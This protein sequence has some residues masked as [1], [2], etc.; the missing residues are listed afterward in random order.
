M[1]H[2]NIPLKLKIPWGGMR[3]TPKTFSVQEAYP[4]L[5][6]PTVSWRNSYKNKF[7]CSSQ[8]VS[9]CVGEIHWVLGKYIGSLIVRFSYLAGYKSRLRFRKSF[10]LQFG[11]FTRIFIFSNAFESCAVLVK[12]MAKT[13]RSWQNVWTCATE[14]CPF[15]SVSW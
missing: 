4:P 5:P 13:S 9:A 12:D 6:S 3:S 8:R 15:V 2:G 11:T 14:R 1:P 10:W 7:W